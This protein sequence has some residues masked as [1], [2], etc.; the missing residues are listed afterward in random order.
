M[1]SCLQGIR[2]DAPGALYV[3]RLDGKMFAA[4]ASVPPTGKLTDFSLLRTHIALTVPADNPRAILRLLALLRIWR[5]GRPLGPLAALRKANVLE[6]FETQIELIACG[7]DWTEK[8]HRYRARGTPLEQLQRD[9]GGSPGFASRMRTN[10]WT[11][12]SDSS[13]ARSAF[14]SFAKTYGV[15]DDKRVCDLALTLAF[16]PASIRLNDPKQGARDFEA[17]ANVPVL[18]RGAYFAKMTSDLRYA[19]PGTAAGAAE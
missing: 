19:E 13:R 5:I 1:D 14:F 6:V 2:I 7:R 12:Y 10:D 4:F 8:A 18:A 15:C 16:H 9:V 11:W 3:A 17:L